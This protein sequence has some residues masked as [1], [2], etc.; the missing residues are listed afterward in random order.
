[1]AAP[2][3]SNNPLSHGVG[4]SA[5]SLLGAEQ[6]AAQLAELGPGHGSSLPAVLTQEPLTLLPQT[7]LLLHRA[8]CTWP[9]LSPLQ[10][11]VTDVTH[12]ATLTCPGGLSSSLP[13]VRALLTH[14]SLLIPI[15]SCSWDSLVYAGSGRGETG[16]L[17]G[18]PGQPCCTISK[19]PGKW[20]CWDTGHPIQGADS[21]HEPSMDRR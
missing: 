12:A 6:R 17:V 4:P 19:H 21:V 8:A 14:P 9:P 1:M 15:L 16:C 18:C 2:E 20:M 5:C 3:T 10:F 11:P 13:A 7:L